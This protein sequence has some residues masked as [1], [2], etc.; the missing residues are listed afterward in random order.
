MPKNKARARPRWCRLKV[1]TTMPSAAGN[2]MAPP[3][4]CTTRNVT[5]HAS[6]AAP[7]GVRPHMAE[8]AAKMIDPEHHHLAV[9]DGVGQTAAEGEQ[10]RQ[11]QQVGVDGPLHS[12]CW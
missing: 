7:F 3:A 11:R 8:A 5:I 6:A 12:R 1:C 9:P 4:P 2:M 10:G